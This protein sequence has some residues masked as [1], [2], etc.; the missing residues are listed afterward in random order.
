MN[1]WCHL[2]YTVGCN[3]ARDNAGA[4]SPSHRNQTSARN[5]VILEKGGDGEGPHGGGRK[6]GSP[7]WEWG[8]L[9]LPHFAYN[10]LMT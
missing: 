2:T 9:F 3:H 1:E 7:G 6:D 8:S 4:R 10:L 5:T